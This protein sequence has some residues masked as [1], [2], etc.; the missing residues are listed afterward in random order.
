MNKQAHLPMVMQPGKGGAK[1][2]SRVSLTPA[3]TLETTN[4]RNKRAQILR[5]SDGPV[6]PP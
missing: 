5:A 4:R 1:G 3:H 2:Q 6:G